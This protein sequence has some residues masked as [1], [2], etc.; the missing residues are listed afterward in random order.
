[1]LFAKNASPKNASPN[2]PDITLPETVTETVAKPRKKLF[3]PWVIV[4]IFAGFAGLIISIPLLSNS[5]SCVNKVMESEAR[6][7]LGS[8][9]R[10]Q[11]AYFY[12]HA[13]FAPDAET[14]MRDTFGSDNTSATT[15]WRDSTRYSYV[16]NANQTPTFSQQSAIAK[17]ASFKSLTVLTIATPKAPQPKALPTTGS[18]PKSSQSKS[19]QYELLTVLCESI[20]KTQSV[21]TVQPGTTTCP[22]DFKTRVSYRSDS[23]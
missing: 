18:K 3:R 2:S 20:H 16:I 15:T 14:L 19:S 6:E 17:N 9:A 13:R 21:P 12:K 10:G 1:M 4:G 23:L 7:L 11:Q 5:M 8:V 22:K